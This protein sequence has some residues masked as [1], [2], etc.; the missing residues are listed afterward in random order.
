MKKILLS[1]AGYD[2]TSGAGVTLDIS[3][4][5]Y[6]GFHGMG[7]LSSL[8]VQNTEKVQKVQCLSSELL[9][10]QYEILMQDV[11]LAGIKIGMIGCK[12]N[13]SPVSKILSMNRDIPC[14]ID[15]VFKSSSGLWLLE[16]SA[17]KDYTKKIHG[18]ADLITPNIE[19][20]SLISGMKIVQEEN[21]QEAAERIYSLSG[22][23]CLLKGSHLKSTSKDILYDGN[24]FYSFKWKKIRKKVHGTGCFLSSCILG[25]LASD[26]PLNE[27]CQLAVQA[28]SEAVRNAA[29]IGHGQSI[30]TF[31]PDSSLLPL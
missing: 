9:R 30:I 2:P 24:R 31:P 6:L 27:A 15:P 19:E 16:K 20:A 23:P 14:V 25:Y 22:I 21:M 29:R 28:T 4:F 1:I 17:V 26:K 18:K 7:I 12:E 5:N 11:A 13:I 8:T 10:N 3:T